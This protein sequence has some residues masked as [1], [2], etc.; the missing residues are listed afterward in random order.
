M[1]MMFQTIRE[2]QKEAREGPVNLHALAARLGIEIDQRWL[3]DDMSGALIRNK[4]GS[5]TI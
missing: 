5:Y 2:T 1:T 3:D 4:D